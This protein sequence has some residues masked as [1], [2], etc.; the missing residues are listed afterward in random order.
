MDSTFGHLEVGELHVIY[1]GPENSFTFYT[2]LKAVCFLI[3]INT[4]Q[5]EE[6]HLGRGWHWQGYKLNMNAQRLMF[7]FLEYLILIT[8]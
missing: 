4:T 5:S 7:V 3:G 8:E 6:N 1:L 2:T